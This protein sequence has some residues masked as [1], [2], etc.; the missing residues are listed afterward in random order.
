MVVNNMKDLA[1]I[2]ALLQAN[3]K[4]H[5]GEIRRT[6]WLGGFML[7]Q[8]LM[9]FTLWIVFFGSVGEVRGWHLQDVALMYGTLATA[10]GVAMFVCDGVR[11]ISNHIQD[12]SIDSFL[13]TPRHSLPALLFSRSNAA[14]LGD[15]L[16]GPIYWFWFGHATIT[17]LPELIILSLLGSITFLSALTAF[18]SLSFWLQRSGRFSDQLF[19][20]LIIFSSIPQHGQPLGIQIVMY[21]LMPAGFISLIPV[22]LL[23]NFSGPQFI[24]L[25]TMAATYLALA[26]LIFNKGVKRYTLGSCS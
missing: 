17:Q 8:N 1:Y 4:A 9:F 6:I 18:Y 11:T 24:L 21:S 26:I 22:A 3:M 20:M 25:A 10:I 7:L 2:F 16:S 14:S 13:T 15:I 5:H 19:E 12:G 23:H